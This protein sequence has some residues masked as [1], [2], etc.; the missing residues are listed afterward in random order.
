MKTITESELLGIV[1]ARV[2]ESQS[3]MCVAAD[4]GISRATLNLVLNGRHPPTPKL[5]KALGYQRVMM[6][7]KRD[8]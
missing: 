3:Q 4:L 5:L 8:K 6:Y 7:R 1:R 2:T